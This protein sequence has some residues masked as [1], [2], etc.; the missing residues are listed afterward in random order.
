MSR[1]GL[2]SVIGRAPWSCLKKGHYRWMIRPRVEALED[3]TLPSFISSTTFQ[4]G[5][6]PN[7]VAVGDFN[8]DHKLDLIAVNSGSNSVNVLLGN[9][10]GSFGAPTN[11]FLNSSPAAVAVGDFNGDHK[12]DVAAIDGTSACSSGMETGR[13][14]NPS[15]CPPALFRWRLLSLI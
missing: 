6:Q 15:T 12:L 1:S 10:D 11:F 7:G 2:L 8:G 14:R 5:Y 13:S 3:R 9:G 4:A